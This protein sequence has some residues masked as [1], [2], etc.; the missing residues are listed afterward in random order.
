[1]RKKGNLNKVTLDR[2][3]FLQKP[4]TKNQIIKKFGLNWD[5]CQVWIHRHKIQTVRVYS[6]KIGGSIIYYSALTD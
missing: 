2:L 3:R 1:M 6:K 4:K 5:S